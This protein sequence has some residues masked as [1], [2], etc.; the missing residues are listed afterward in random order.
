MRF[1]A[2]LPQT[3]ATAHSCNCGLIFPLL[4]PYNARMEQHSRYKQIENHA[5]ALGLCVMGS[6]AAAD[7]GPKEAHN[8]SAKS[9]GPLILLGTGPSFWSQLQKTPEFSDGLPD[10]IDRWSSRV[11]TKLATDLG[12]EAHF[13]F[14]GPPYK[15]FVAWAHLS[16]RFFTSPSQMLVHDQYGMMISLR[17]ALEFENDFST[18]APALVSSPCNSCES[19][20]CISTCPVEAMPEGGPYDVVGCGRHLAHSEGA[21]CLFGGCVARRACPLSA[22]AQRDPAQTSH[23][24][25]A[26]LAN[27]PSATSHRKSLA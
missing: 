9:Y 8:P 16:G 17:G 6:L 26:F 18:P 23:H 12:A 14:D 27:L 11:L 10:P 24:M 4:P 7:R 2:C 20:A 25:Q 15:P 3:Q 5:E 22:G 13:P 21:P 19:R 1:D